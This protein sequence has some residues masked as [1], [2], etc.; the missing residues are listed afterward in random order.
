ME[1][2]K[3]VYNKGEFNMDALK[4]G[5]EMAMGDKL[6]DPE[7]CKQ[8]EDKH[9]EDV[10]KYNMTY[11]DTPTGDLYIGYE[12]EI[13]TSWGYVAGKWPEILG[14]DTHVALFGGGATLRSKWLTKE[15]IESCGWEH[16]GGQLISTGRQDY[17]IGNYILRHYCYSPPRTLSLVTIYTKEDPMAM[18]NYS[19]VGKCLFDGECKSIN[20]LKTLMKWLHIT[21]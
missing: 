14:A 2:K 21:N 11:Y 18:G 12:C 6:N 13:Q 19:G 3:V 8:M 5:L 17:Q 7:W 20:E 10:E 9:K 15:Q 16:T 1:D 4:K